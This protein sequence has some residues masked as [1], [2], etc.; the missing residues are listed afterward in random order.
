MFVEYQNNK[1]VG[2]AT[3]KIHGRGDYYGEVQLHYY[4]YPKAPSGLKASKVMDTYAKLNWSISSGADSYE[5]YRYDAASK[6]Y[7]LAADVGNTT[8][9][10]VTGL[11]MQ[12]TYHFVV[13]G[14]KTVDGT[15]YN[16]GWSNVL[17]VTTNAASADVVSL[18]AN[19]DGQSI[20]LSE[21]GGAQ[22]LF[23]PASADLTKL[24]LRFEISENKGTLT[25]SGN[26]GS[27]TLDTAEQTVDLT[28]LANQSNGSY[29]FTAK[30]GGGDALTVHVMQGTGIPTLYLT[31]SAEGQNRDWVDASKENKTT[32]AARMIAVNGAAI[33]DG[34]VKQLKARGNS[35]FLHADKKSYQMKLSDGADLLGTGEQVKTWVLLAGYFDATQMHDKLVKD[36]AAQLGMGYT[37]S[38]GWVNLYYDGEY[39]GIYLLSEKN[40]ISKTSVNINDLEKQYE[41]LYRLLNGGE[42]GTNMNVEAGKNQDG[43]AVYY[44]TN[45]TDPKNATD[46]TGGYLLEM[47]YRELDEPNGFKTKQGYAFN[48]KSPEWCGKKAVDY[49]SE[50]YQGFE[51]AV[52]AADGSGYNAATGKYYYQYVDLDSLVKTFVLQELAKNC[53]GFRYSQFFYFTNGK[54]YAGPVWDQE[55]TFGTGWS[56]YSKPDSMEYFDLGEALIRIPHF[57]AAVRAYYSTVRKAA[58]GLESRVN[59]QYAALCDSAA[60]NYTLW[61]YIRVGNPEAAGRIWQGASYE[62]VINDLQSWIA[63]RLS[64]LDEVYADIPA[65]KRGDV[66]GDGKVS[67][68]DL[69]VLRKYIAGITEL[70]EAQ[71]KAADVNNDGKVSMMDVLWLRQYLSGLRDENF[72]KINV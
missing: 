62:A 67:M 33:Y 29:V 2:K 12:K 28:A 58:S 11:D 45:L 56:G 5:L 63:K 7:V 41:E 34:S 20:A 25:L 1:Q 68:M 6:Q 54:L 14:T 38:C 15:A 53:D 47:N 8:G 44:T 22:Y 37:A 42:Y 26:K 39:R 66:N 57:K 13:R 18:T 35:T 64:K 61:P 24:P 32:A 46:G 27:L 31:S 71:M 21:A 16:S 30:I 36:L 3:V 60:M 17:S 10:T 55:L 43:C 19:V 23:L 70:T 69:L 51:D 9:Y 40:D 4:I 50:Y 59:A 72:E 49:I 65:A 48:I 52:Y